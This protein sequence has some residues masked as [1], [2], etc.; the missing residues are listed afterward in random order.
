MQA[1]VFATDDGQG[2]EGSGPTLVIEDVPTAW[3]P[4]ARTFSITHQFLGRGLVKARRRPVP[5]HG[6]DE[7]R[8]RPVKP[9]GLRDGLTL[10]QLGRQQLV[11]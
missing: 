1:L 2:T 8:D 3:F 6:L 4:T 10:S 9:P 5:S 7:R 11:S